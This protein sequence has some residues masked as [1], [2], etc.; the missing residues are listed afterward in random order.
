MAPKLPVWFRVAAQNNVQQ[1][2][3]FVP[4]DQGKAMNQRKDKHGPGRNWM[5]QQL[6]VNRR[7]LN[8]RNTV[9]SK[10]TSETKKHMNTMR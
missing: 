8:R 4:M 6:T 1:V 10:T 5:P 9:G 7:I 3:V 2:I